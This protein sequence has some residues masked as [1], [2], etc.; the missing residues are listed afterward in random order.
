MFQPSIIFQRTQAG[1]DEI[2]QKS[3]GLT[4]SERLVLIMID[5]ATTCGDV[6]S[7][8]PALTDERFKRAL[9]SL[10]KKE[11]IFEVFMPTEE[12]VAEELEATVVDRF[13]QQDALDPVTIIS[14]DPDDEFGDVPELEHKV[15]EPATPRQPETPPPAKTLAKDFPV[16]A[17]ALATEFA[18]IDAFTKEQYSTPIV[19][20]QSDIAAA[21]QPRGRPLEE[22][23]G[24]SAAPLSPS[25]PLPPFVNQNVPPSQVATPSRVNRLDGLHLH[26][27]YL[28]IGIGLAFIVGYALGRITG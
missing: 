23:G 5:G 14:F 13:L 22:A 15:Q 11:L 9:A 27:G 3:H 6:R 21:P 7:K 18:E 19:A 28:L 17:D 24:C 10:E 4:Q 26:W 2:Y 16:L 25:R 8:V 1:R 20:V 12:Q